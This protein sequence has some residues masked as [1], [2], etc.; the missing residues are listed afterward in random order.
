MVSLVICS[1]NPQSEVI[2]S[3]LDAIRKQTMSPEH[4][5][6]VIVD[7]ASDIP[8]QSILPASLL[9]NA[10]VVDE[11]VLGLTH[12]RLCGI[13][14][15][16]FPMIVFVDDDNSLDSN[17]LEKALEIANQ[18]PFLGAWGGQIV[19][20]FIS[21]PEP[22]MRPY[23]GLLALCEFDRDSWSN[24]IDSL[25]VVP[26]GAGLCV[27]RHVA[28]HY[29]LQVSNDPRRAALDRR[30][31]HLAAHGDTDLALTSCDLGLGTGRFTSLRL[32]HLIPSNRLEL[33]YLIRLS[34]AMSCS[35]L[36][37][38]SLRGTVKIHRLGTIRKLLGMI[39]RRLTMR[40]EDRLLA[41]ARLRGRLK[42]YEILSHQDRNVLA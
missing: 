3:C 22:W 8:I 35:D 31:T 25:H 16:R 2:R 10:K 17:Y 1:H 20:R 27:R 41:E 40:R 33:S 19:P 39:K 13:R 15:S 12:A 36:I 9:T 14:H 11:P 38:R 37:L 6:L 42:A 29:A 18:Y 30:G 4:F 26:F 7:N 34:E 24:A 21:P 5:E 28:E 32:E 23:W